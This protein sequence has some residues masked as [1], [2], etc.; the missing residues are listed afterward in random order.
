V[1]RSALHRGCR[2][3]WDRRYKGSILLRADTEFAIDEAELAEPDDD[4]RLDR[5][6][7][8]ARQAEVLPPL[9]RWRGC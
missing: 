5:I 9:C 4:E 3:D 7:E 8:L 2:L 6:V 1:P